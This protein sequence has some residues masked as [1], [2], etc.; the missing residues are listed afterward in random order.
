[1]AKRWIALL[2]CAL[3]AGCALGSDDEVDGEGD[4]FL[5]DGKS[6]TGGVADGSPEAAAV[7]EVANRTSEALLA[8]AVG[9]G[10]AGLDKRAAANIA[11][12]RLGADGA[13]GTDD[14]ETFTRLAELD[15]VPFVGP[16]AFQK[17]LAYAMTPA[18]VDAA[19]GPACDR[20]VATPPAGKHNPGKRCTVC[21]TGNGSAPRWTAAGTL[22][23]DAAGTTAVAGATIHI[24]DA[25]GTELRLVTADNGN[26]WTST[27]LA[28]PVRV[29][30]SRCP[31]GAEMPEPIAAWDGC[32]GCHGTGKRIHLP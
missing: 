5:V 17:L 2:V 6:D 22:Y 7:L 8:R 14:D 28:Y 27:P 15:A 3:G 4:A 16:I 10:G 11:A 19:P 31:D 24:I 30:A 23:S 32:N 20:P 12:T 1:M 9:D 29:R 18:R 21:H 25:A 13:Q 26:F